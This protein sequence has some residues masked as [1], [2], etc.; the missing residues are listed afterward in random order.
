MGRRL[1]PGRKAAIC[2][3]LL[4]LAVISGGSS[5]A[6]LA[7]EMPENEVSGRVLFISSYSYAWVTVPQQIEGIQETL[8]SHVVLDYKFMDTKN[9]DTPENTQLFYENMKYFLQNVL[10]Y[11]V[12]IVG[13]DAAFQFAMEHQQELFADTP[14]IFE[15]IND[16]EFALE[17]S[18]DPYVTGVIENL[19]YE[20]TI[21]LA[22]RM[23]PQATQVV[24]ILD[25]TISGEGERTEYYKFASQFPDLEFKE[26]NASRLTRDEL[27]R[28][29]EELGDESILL[30]VFCSEDADGNTYVTSKD[31][32]V[33]SE[34]ANIPI[35]STVPVGIGD[36]FLG[37]EVVSLKQIG[38]LAG[39]MTMRVLNG[40]DCSEIAVVED[41]PT[42]YRFD[43]D[44]MNRFGIESLV[45]PK[46]AEILNHKETFLERYKIAIQIGC[47]VVLFFL[48]LV[49]FLLLDNMRSKRM[50]ED[51][52]RANERLSET[53]RH[54]T[55]TQMLNRKSFMDDLQQKI[56][57]GEPF[58][59]MMYDL[60]GLKKI[61]D[62]Y[63][64]NEGDA[65]LKAIAKCFKHLS[66]DTFTGY[67]L[68]GDE[69]TAIVASGDRKLVESYADR[70]LQK[71]RESYH[72]PSSDEC[73][74]SSIGIAMWPADEKE[75]AEL[76]ATADKA[77]YFIK[78][79]GKD[80]IAFYG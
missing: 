38:R 52:N 74:H 64:H 77:M 32:G 69:F 41:S 50:N 59:V 24:A 22:N 5:N 70:L 17:A 48:F 18:K 73:L 56:D 20:N 4:L 57:E 53:V 71:T 60:D 40:E 61:N 26:I 54:D 15:G 78:K 63:G 35:F 43:E 3:A 16:T 66:D 31:I 6:A 44:V 76:L 19:S 30:Y 34:Y 11:D 80:G 2:L 68:A 46:D 29:L 8:G 36:G 79:N 51:A 62:T 67:R 75:G 10:P 12:I 39:E 27:F 49:A 58:A 7:S 21:D 33:L 28:Q 55:L 9:V 72:L 13:D 65:V 42:V 1:F 37:G 47:V 45:L 23:Y 25:D 14:I